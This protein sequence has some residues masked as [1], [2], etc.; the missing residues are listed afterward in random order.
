MFGLVRCHVASLHLMLDSYRR[1]Q[2]SMKLKKCIFCVPYGIFLGHVAYKK[3]LMVDPTK[4]VVIFNLEAPNNVNQLR[5]ML[6][7]TGYYRN[8]IKAYA[9]I[10][11]PMEKLLKKD[12]TFY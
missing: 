9:Q 12:T 11:V 5:A 7:H 6:G 3:L 8:F 4:I 10:A 2:I 1:Y